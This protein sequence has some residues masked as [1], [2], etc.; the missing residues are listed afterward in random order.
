[1]A[2]FILYALRMWCV[3]LLDEVYC[4][5]LAKF[6]TKAATDSTFTIVISSR[7]LCLVDVRDVTFNRA[8]VSN[9]EG[10][11][12]VK[13]KVLRCNFIHCLKVFTKTRDAFKI[14]K[15]NSK[16]P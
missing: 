11:S 4:I 3:G 7:H 8:I 16:T 9:H 2:H 1:M 14:H 6:D 5:N 10:R 15:S 13:F 12:K